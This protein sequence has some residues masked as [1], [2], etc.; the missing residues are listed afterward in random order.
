MEVGLEVERLLAAD[1]KGAGFLAGAPGDLLGSAF[2]DPEAPATLS[3]RT[4]SHFRIG[5]P[6]GSGGM[7][8]VY[9]A[10]DIR[11]GR[12]VALK[13]LAPELVRDPAAKARF[14][15]EAR[16][17]SALDHANL[18]TILE[19]GESEDGLL[20]LAMPRYHGESL[21]RRI[22]RGPLPVKEALEIAV[23]PPAGSP[24]RTSMGSSTAT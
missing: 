21:K 16:A 13:F 4:V 20:F 7:G 8:V 17:A 12:S 11:L 6:L 2:E 19:V 10:E 14:L 18:C 23:Q 3:G 1:E 24:R 9:E 15:T 5:E 22:D